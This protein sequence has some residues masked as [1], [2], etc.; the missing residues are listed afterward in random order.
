GPAAVGA[1]AASAGVDD[2]GRGALGD[3]EA[4]GGAPEEHALD[5]GAVREE[6]HVAA[7]PARDAAGD[8]EADAGAPERARG[9]SVDLVEGLEDAVGTLARHARAGVGDEHLVG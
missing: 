5:G 8:R 1:S 6:L 4:E 3:R 9:R 7:E 2:D